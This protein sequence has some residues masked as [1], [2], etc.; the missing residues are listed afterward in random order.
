MEKVRRQPEIQM[1]LGVVL[2]LCGAPC[3][4]RNVLLFFAI[5]HL[6]YRNN[7]RGNIW[8]NKKEMIARSEKVQIYGYQAFQMDRK[9]SLACRF[10]IK[11]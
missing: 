9:S 8:K 7:D 4:K 10:S 1:N 11:D 2:R 6:L 5:F 3:N